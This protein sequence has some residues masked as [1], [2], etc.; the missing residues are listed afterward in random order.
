MVFVAMISG[1]WIKR[2]FVVS[3]SIR[4]AILQHGGDVVAGAEGETAALDGQHLQ[5]EVAQPYLARLADAL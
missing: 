5:T 1:S 4:Q 3:L 2:H